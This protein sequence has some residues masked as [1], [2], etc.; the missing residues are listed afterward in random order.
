MTIGVLAVQGAYAE[1]IRALRG[2]NITAVEIRRAADMRRRFDGFIFPGGE[3]T[4]IGKLVRELGLYAPL[5]EAIVRGIPVFGTCAGLILLAADI[6]GEPAPH[7]G[8]MD[9]CAVRNAYGRQLGSFEAVSEFDGRA[10]LMPFIRAPYA[11]AL[12]RGVEAL[13]SV[14]GRVVAAR[15]NNQLVTAF[16]PELTGDNTVHTYFLGMCERAKES[17]GEEEVCGEKPFLKKVFSPAPP[18]LKTSRSSTKL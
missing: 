11:K 12:G 13:A 14:G 9:F 4:A 6:E 7:F 2:L 5:K 15:Q 3:S 17:S 18:F 1:H 10:V 8:T 16:H